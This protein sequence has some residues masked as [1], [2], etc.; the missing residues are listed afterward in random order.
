MHRSVQEVY[1]HS[2]FIISP[3]WSPFGVHL[4]LFISLDMIGFL[5]ILCG[6]ERAV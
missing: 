6:D 4:K 2:L 1:I 5:G 3:L